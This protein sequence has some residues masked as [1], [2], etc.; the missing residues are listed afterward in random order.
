MHDARGDA[1]QLVSMWGD[2]VSLDDLREGW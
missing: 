1:E 2:R